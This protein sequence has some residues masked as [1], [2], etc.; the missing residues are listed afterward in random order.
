MEKR[1][2]LESH[3]ELR[4]LVEKGWKLKDIA[5][6]FDI[7][8]TTAWKYAHRTPESSEETDGEINSEVQSA[9][10]HN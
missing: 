2:S 8:I 10:D 3:K 4:V 7:S 5:N 9:P 1:L 6:R